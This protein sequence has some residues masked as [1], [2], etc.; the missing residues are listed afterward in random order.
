[1]IRLLE[2]LKPLLRMNIITNIYME[3]DNSD[4]IHTCAN[5]LS[6]K[7]IRKVIIVPDEMTTV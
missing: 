6:G 7:S 4:I 1:M 3:T 5:V 2:H